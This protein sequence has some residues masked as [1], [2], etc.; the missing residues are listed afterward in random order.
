MSEA[1]SSI[2]S[3]IIVSGEERPGQI[4]ILNSIELFRNLH[5]KISASE[6]TSSVRR[7]MRAVSVADLTEPVR[8]LIGTPIRWA[9]YRGPCQIASSRVVVKSAVSSLSSL[10]AMNISMISWTQR[11]LLVEAA[12][13]NIV[14][15]DTS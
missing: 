11:F 7:R 5:A 13:V 14:L 1:T 4:S 12:T 6:G 8:F 9:D 2:C 3:R 10:E 15:P